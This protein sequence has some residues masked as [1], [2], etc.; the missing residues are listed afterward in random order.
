MRIFHSDKYMLPTFMSG[1]GK[2]QVFLVLLYKARTT[3]ISTYTKYKG[4]AGA[5]KGN[6]TQELS[7]LPASWFYRH[8]LPL[9]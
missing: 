3:E 7:L 2:Q 8:Q 9:C 5:G 1:V 6:T 4:Q